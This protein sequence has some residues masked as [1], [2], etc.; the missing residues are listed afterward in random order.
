M[1][2]IPGATVPPERTLSPPRV[3]LPPSVPPAFTLA[4]EVIDPFTASRP[5]FTSVLPV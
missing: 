1:P 5:P 2:P 4:T 3:P